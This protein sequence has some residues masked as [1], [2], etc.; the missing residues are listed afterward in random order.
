[1]SGGSPPVPPQGW[2]YSYPHYTDE[3]MQS[4]EETGLRGSSR[5]SLGSL[6]VRPQDAF[7]LAPSGG[8]PWANVPLQSRG[9]GVLTPEPQA[10]SG[11]RGALCVTDIYRVSGAMPSGFRAL[12]P[13]RGLSYCPLLQDLS[14]RGS[15][16]SA[17][18]PLTVWDIVAKALPLPLGQLRIW[19]GQEAGQER[20]GRSVC[21][22]P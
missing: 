16:V 22:A 7:L 21:R 17:L 13:L 18:T 8:M 14:Q 12:L 20:R 19:G 9:R 15:Q 3:E 5:G 11:P 1:M 4:P 10:C 6:G 2:C